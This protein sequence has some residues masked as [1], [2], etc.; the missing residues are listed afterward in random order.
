MRL[1]SQFTL[2]LVASLCCLTS[3]TPTTTRKSKAIHPNKQGKNSWTSV[4]NQLRRRR[5]QTQPNAARFDQTK[6][7]ATTLPVATPVWKQELLHRAKVG[8]YFGLWYALNIVYNSKYSIDR[9][10]HP[11]SIPLSSGIVS[12]AIYAMI[13]PLVVVVVSRMFPFPPSRQQK[14][15]Q[16]MAGTADHRDTP[17]GHRSFICTDGLDDGSS[18]ASVLC[19]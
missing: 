13:S 1:W 5:R 12:F 17:I 8:F 9:S 18:D 7:A 15:P 14:S 4:T 2:L 11:S 10:I 6:A 19:E 3:S 16:C